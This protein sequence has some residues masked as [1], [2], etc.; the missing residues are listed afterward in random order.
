MRFR[1]LNLHKITVK[2]LRLFL[3]AFSNQLLA[4]DFVLV[5]FAGKCLCSRNLAVLPDGAK[6][7]DLEKIIKSLS[8]LSGASCSLEDCALCFYRYDRASDM[9]EPINY[10]EKVVDVRKIV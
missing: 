7:H 3:I 1:I 9:Y 6:Y 4:I 2:L 10:A 8:K 5:N